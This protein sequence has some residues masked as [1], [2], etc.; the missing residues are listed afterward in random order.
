MKIRSRPGKRSRAKPYAH[1]AAVS[2]VPTMV[3]TV[4]SS[5]L[6]TNRMNGSTVSASG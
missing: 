6:L 5:V 2:S 3:I 4:T 1:S